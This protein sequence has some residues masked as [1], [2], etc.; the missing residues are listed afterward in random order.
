[1][2][3]LS[4]SFKKEIENQPEDYFL[5]YDMYDLLIDE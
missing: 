4:H 5:T 2:D 3:S 1:M